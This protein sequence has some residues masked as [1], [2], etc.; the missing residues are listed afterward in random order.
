MNL[1]KDERAALYDFTVRDDAPA[2]ASDWRNAWEASSRVHEL[3]S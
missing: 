3:T 2:S 1:T